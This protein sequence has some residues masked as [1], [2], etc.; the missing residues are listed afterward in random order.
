[1][2]LAVLV[3]PIVFHLL[4]LLP[5]SSDSQKYIESSH[6]GLETLKQMTRENT[7]HIDEN[8]VKEIALRLGVAGGDWYDK[9]LNP[10]ISL[11]RVR[12]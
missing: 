10:I 1:M 8:T 7:I 3:M 4:W 11:K 6:A 9:I 12:S 5:A 2:I